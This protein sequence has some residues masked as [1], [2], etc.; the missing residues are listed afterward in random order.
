MEIF[1]KVAVVLLTCAI[2]FFGCSPKSSEIIVLEVGQQKVTLAEYENFYTR[3]SG[4]WEMGQKSSL[5]ERE[6][7]LDLLTNYKLKLQDAYDRN[8]INDTDI[9]S[10]LRE[11]RVSLAT[12]FMTDREITI[13]GVKKLYDRR[14]EEIRAQHILLKVT[15]EAMPEETLKTYNKA[16][17][18]IRRAKVG[19]NFDSLAIQ[20]SD[21]PSAKFNAGDIYYFTGGQMVTPFE[22]AAYGMKK[23]EIS[24]TPVR[25][26]F[27]YHIIRILDRQPVRGSIRVSHI[28]T[29]FQKSASDS[30]DTAAA[31]IRIQSLQDSLKKGWDFHKLAVKLSED[32]GSAP[33]GGDLGWFDRRRFVQPFDEAAFKL[34]AGE[35]SPII[36]TPFGYHLISCDSAKPVPPHAILSEDLKK[37]YQQQRYNEDYSSYLAKLKKDYQYQFNEEIF[38]KFISSLDSSK[39]TDDSAWAGTVP[40]EIKMKP[41]MVING[42]QILLDTVIIVLEKRPEYQ[43]TLLRAP[44][45]RTRI[46]RI[47]DGLL[48]ETKSIGLEQRYP[49]FANLMKEY[50]DGIV[51]YKAEQLEV[52]NKTTVSDTA[53]RNYYEQNASKFVFPDRVNIT[54]LVLDTDTLAF[55]VYDSLKKGSDF[56]DMVNRYRE[57]PPP[58]LSDG[59][60]GLQP[61]ETDELTKRAATMAVDEI[62]EPITTEDGTY[63][64][65]KLNTKESARQKTYEEAGAEVSNAYQ[66]ASSKNLEKHWLDRVKQRHPVKQNKEVLLKAFTSPPAEK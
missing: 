56:S 33:Q 51:L 10:E 48:L 43:N 63:A 12:S 1:Q 9:V 18:L 31:R 62:S 11:Y 40:S 61:V 2:L 6:R 13:P 37:I 28:M 54:A 16:M 29:R 52:W 50:T 21:D 20:N 53:L 65:I 58:K 44:E 55:M 14:K 64:I 60:R 46:N 4:G 8:L 25:S 36:R 17:D 35:I 45:L 39:T 41:L 3:N 34:K 19:E 23:G 15:P 57:M 26:T 24:Q 30:A 66:E 27:G 49:E 42:H 32:A 22:N 47:A 7:F 59:S 38:E 5:E